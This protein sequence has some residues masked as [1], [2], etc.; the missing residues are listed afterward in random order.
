M[1]SLPEPGSLTARAH[2]AAMQGHEILDNRQT[3]AEAAGRPGQ[4]T[5]AL[6]EE[7]K[8][9]RQQ[10]AR[11]ADPVISDADHYFGRFV[12]DTHGHDDPVAA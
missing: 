6:T 11:D 1:N 10:V 4:W 9:M 2:A 5:L 3:D 7:I 8:D 12:R